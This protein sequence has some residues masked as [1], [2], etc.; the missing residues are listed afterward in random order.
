MKSS[1]FKPTATNARLLLFSPPRPPLESTALR[2]PLLFY[3]S[4]SSC[5]LFQLLGIYLLL[6]FLPSI[7]QQPAMR[8]PSFRQPAPVFFNDLRCIF[9]SHPFHQLR[10]I[11]QLPAMRSAP[12]FSLLTPTPGS[13]L[14][15]TPRNRLRCIF[16]HPPFSPA[17][18]NFSTTYNTLRGTNQAS[19]DKTSV[20]GLIWQSFYAR[21]Y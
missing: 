3:P 1:L 19:F 16:Y 18:I 10:S 20:P 11:F 12:R 4:A 2:P 17:A 13:Q 8:R 9:L 14:S 15:H 21:L 6:A 7:F 5:G